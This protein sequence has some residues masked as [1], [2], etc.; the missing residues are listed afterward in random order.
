MKL[1]YLDVLLAVEE[2]ESSTLAALEWLSQAR[3]TQIKAPK[4]IALPV[5][6]SERRSRGFG[7]GRGRSR[8]EWDEPQVRGRGGRFRGAYRQDDYDDVIENYGT[9]RGGRGRSRGRSRGGYDNYDDDDIA[10]PVVRGSFRGRG[11]GSLNEF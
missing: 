7:R 9:Y 10:M 6:S 5:S 2:E 3:S 8:D 4:D 1:K 11:R